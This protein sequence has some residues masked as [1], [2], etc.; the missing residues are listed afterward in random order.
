MDTVDRYDTD[1]KNLVIRQ[2]SVLE[3]FSIA[4]QPDAKLKISCLVG[5]EGG[6]PEKEEVVEF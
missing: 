1:R 3:F 6:T 5:M 2:L 4:S